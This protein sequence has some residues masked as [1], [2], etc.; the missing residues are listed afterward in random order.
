MALNSQLPIQLSLDD[1]YPKTK[2]G[3]LLGDAQ[4]PQKSLNDKQRHVLQGLQQSIS[5]YN[6]IQMGI[7]LGVTEFA[8][9]AKSACYLELIKIAVA[10]IKEFKVPHLS[11][12]DENYQVPD[13]KVGW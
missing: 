9:S 13:Y 2:R 5:R 8:A 6:S 12:K 11:Y 1:Y 3:Y 10:E 7:A 4:V